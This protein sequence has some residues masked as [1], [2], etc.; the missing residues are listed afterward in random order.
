M[1]KKYMCQVAQYVPCGTISSR[2]MIHVT[3]THGEGCV[4]VESRKA[5]QLVN[6]ITML[7]NKAVLTMVNQEQ[8]YLSA[9]MYIARS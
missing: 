4:R 5:S 6:L 7:G 2:T 3:T 8:E 9:Q 1:M